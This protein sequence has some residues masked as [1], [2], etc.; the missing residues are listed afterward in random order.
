MHNPHLDLKYPLASKY[1]IENDE[2]FS[3]A[4]GVKGEKEF[5]YA[6]DYDDHYQLIASEVKDDYV[7]A[8]F[9]CE[10]RDGTEFTQ[11][12]KIT[13]DGVEIT[14]ESCGTVSILIPALHFDGKEYSNISVTENSVCVDY[15][16]STCVYS[17]NGIVSGGEKIYANRNGHYKGFKT[18]AYGSVTLKI[19]IT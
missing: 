9:K 10:L 19:S 5:V 3:I 14:A 8:T 12:C 17:T 13:N 18:C 1:D 11:I 4:C 16:G 6:T 2:P 7:S 15:K